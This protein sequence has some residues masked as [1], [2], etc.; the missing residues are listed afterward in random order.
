MIVKKNTVRDA[1][2]K[3]KDEDEKIEEIE[4]YSMDDEFD[5]DTFIKLN[6][7]KTFDEKANQ[8]QLD[9][10]DLFYK[11]QFFTEAKHQFSPVAQNGN[12]ETISG[13][14]NRNA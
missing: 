3:E 6:N 2:K 13:H 7:D 11:E 5:E 4:E 9:E 14:K 8:S 12:Q 1:L 10:Y